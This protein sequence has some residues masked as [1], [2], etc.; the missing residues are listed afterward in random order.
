MRS[1]VLIQDHTALIVMPQ[2]LRRHPG[3]VNLFI[4][5]F[6]DTSLVSIVAPVRARSC[7]PRF[8]IRWPTPTT[9]SPALCLHRH[10]LFRV[11]SCFACRVTRCSVEN[12][13]G[14]P[15]GANWHLTM[16]TNLDRRHQRL[17]KW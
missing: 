2:A 16:S 5:L 8:P 13:R 3:L 1:A 11:S 17:N 12:R 4:R 9:C 7:G 6:K 10:D 15:I 14:T